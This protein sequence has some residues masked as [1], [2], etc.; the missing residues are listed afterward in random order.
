[1]Q[2]T[3]VDVITDIVERLTT[4]SNSSHQIVMLSGVAGSGKSTIAKSVA[5][6]LAEKGIL[7]ASF[8]FS[9]DYADRNGLKYF[10]T[11][12]AVQLA[13]YDPMF[14]THLIKLLVKDEHSGLLTLGPHLQFKKMVVEI[15][16]KMPQKSTPWIICLDA[17]DECGTDHGQTFLRWLSDSISQIPA[18]IQFFLT[19][20]P[21]VPSYLKFDTL[22]SLMHGIILD[23]L[24]NATVEQ[25]IRLYVERS[26]DGST[27]ITR[28]PWKIQSG[29]TEE[30]TKRAG[31]LF[32]FAA[33]AV[34]YVLA[35]LPKVLPQKS[36]NYLLDGEPL[37]D[38]HA[39]YKRI[40]DEAIPVPCPGDRR[41]QESYDQCMKALSTI[42]GLHEP[43]DLENLATLLKAET[44][45]LQ[46]ML[47]P[48][49]AVIYVSDTRGAG[50]QVVHLSFRE[51]MM[52]HVQTTRPD[53]CCGTEDQ[54]YSLAS[55]MIKVMQEQLRFNIC[56]LPT[57]YLRNIDMTDFQSQLKTYIPDYLHYACRFWVDHLVATS[58]DSFIA[59][60]VEK[61]LF[62]KFLFW[63][64]VLSLLGMVDHASKSLS[65][66]I[67]WATKVC[68]LCCIM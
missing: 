42:L 12:L 33:T 13:G 64:E 61:L 63:L 43:L 9:R 60:A 2:G 66:L 44:D 20:R 15:L 6:I 45:I 36:I 16:Q 34:R 5:S 19:G 25:D 1:M 29:D 62:K 3:R 10:A 31:G 51:F 52:S 28:N 59:Q 53:I 17:L 39:L 40:V 49:S 24:D 58:Y 14:Q 65:K 37:T 47:V 21:D 68:L 56:A 55:A 23:T 41:A 38:L 30:I 18:H 7:A 11:T 57:S 8:F 22:L 35:G 50:I 32:V 27:W 67:A 54:H 48:L 46:A 26:L 4:N